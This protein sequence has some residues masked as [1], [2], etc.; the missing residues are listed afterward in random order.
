MKKRIWFSANDVFYISA[1]S[2]S[3]AFATTDGKTVLPNGIAVIY[4]QSDKAR[5][6]LR[7]DKCW[8]ACY[9]PGACADLAMQDAI[10]RLTNLYGG[11]APSF[12]DVEDQTT[13]LRRLLKA[14]E[15]TCGQET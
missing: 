2:N 7:E 6:K 9:G 4:Y 12:A 14:C 10:A 5:H 8:V 1:V 3:P 11:V 15:E 13:E